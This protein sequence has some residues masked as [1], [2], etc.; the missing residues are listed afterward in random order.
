MLF[1]YKGFDVNGKNISSNVEASSLNEAKQKV[2]QKKIIC[3]HISEKKFKSI[4]KFSFE[5][6]KISADKLSLFSRDLSIYLKSGISLVKAIKLLKD[7]FKNEKQIK[8][9]LEV[10]ETYLE[11]GKDF[12][13]ALDKQSIFKL[14]EFYKQSIKVSESG[15]LLE[16]VLLELSVFLKE[17][18]RI[19]KQLSSAM[20]YPLF[21]LIISFFMVGFMLSVVVPKI[22]DIFVKQNSEL[23]V[24]TRVVIN[25]GDFVS[26]YYGYIFIIIFFIIG[27]FAYFWKNSYSFKYFIDFNSLKIPFFKGLI[28]LSDLSRFAYMNSILIKSGVPIVQSISLSSNILKNSVLQKIFKMASKKVI[29]GERLSVALE[30]NKY[31]SID[32]TFIQAIAIGEE[33]SQMSDILNNLAVLYNE[34]NKDKLTILLSLMEPI[35][36]LIV[37]AVIGAIVLAML[38]PIFSMNIT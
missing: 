8:N 1:Q 26:S 23:P 11:E 36:M 15:G 13:T 24:I 38:L 34:S 9:F 3:T 37:G 7:R 28:Q 21:I 25:L 17:Q 20:A 27:V 33:T 4:N 31:Y 10:I 30:K 14:P 2:K 16:E 12:F 22:T 6:K 32:T 5:N 19:K 29:E 18:D 35:L